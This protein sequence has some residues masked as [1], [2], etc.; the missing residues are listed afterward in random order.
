MTMLRTILVDDEPRGISSMQKLLQ[1]TC[2]DISIV[3]ACTSAD[4]AMEKIEQTASRSPFF[5]YSNAG[6]KRAA[7]VK[8][9]EWF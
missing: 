8:R 6:K 5:R 4:E 3:A 2:P 1:L 9:T 7:D